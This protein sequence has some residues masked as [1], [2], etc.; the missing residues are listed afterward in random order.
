MLGYV[1][2]ERETVHCDADRLVITCI[3]GFCTC[4]SVSC[5]GV[6]RVNSQNRFIYIYIYIL[7]HSTVL[8]LVLVEWQVC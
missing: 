2:R 7:I 1:T 3:T 8:Y 6:L 5:L 4:Y